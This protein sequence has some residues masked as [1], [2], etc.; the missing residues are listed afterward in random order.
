MKNVNREI[1]QGI[2]EPRFSLAVSTL[3]STLDSTTGEV[4][5]F[6]YAC[7]PYVDASPS[8]YNPW[9][10]VLCLVR[11]NIKQEDER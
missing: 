10:S 11:E 6:V 2:W 1:K 5:E 9:R 3:D 4:Q 8:H 7:M